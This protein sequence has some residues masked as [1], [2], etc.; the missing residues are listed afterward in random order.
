VHEIVVGG[1]PSDTI[2][3]S[4][5]TTDQATASEGE[6]VYHNRA[7]L[8]GKVR[9]GKIVFYE[10]YEDTQKGWNST[11]ILRGKNSAPVRA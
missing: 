7:A 9:W 11:S 6:V 8:P 10:V 5:R 2:I 1:P 3:V 4:I